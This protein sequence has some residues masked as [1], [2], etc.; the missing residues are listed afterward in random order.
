MPAMPAPTSRTADKSG[1]SACERAGHM[2]CCERDRALNDGEPYEVGI[3]RRPF[4]SVDRF[5]QGVAVDHAHHRE[6]HHGR[7]RRHIPAQHHQRAKREHGQCD[8][9]LR[10]RHRRAMQVKSN[11]AHHR[12]HER[13]CQ[14]RC[15]A[16][17]SREAPDRNDRRQMVEADHRMAQ[18]RQDALHR[19]SPACGRPSRDA[20]KPAPNRRPMRQAPN[21][22]VPIAVSLLF[23]PARP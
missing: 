16:V 2:R 1:R 8:K 9:N 5:A 15:R 21:R 14:R 6:Q 19:R 20:R 23:L 13:N 18:S 10:P 17:R 11:A 12:Q 7:P 3:K 4:G 22:D